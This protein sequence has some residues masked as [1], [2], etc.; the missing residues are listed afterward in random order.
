MYCVHRV[1]YSLHYADLNESYQIDHIDCNPLNNSIKNLR[2]ATGQENQ[3]NRPIQ[4]NNKVGSKGV[5]INKRNP[6]KKYRAVIYINKRQINLGCFYTEFEASEAYMLACE[7]HFGEF[8][9]L[10]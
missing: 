5:S 7:L 2:I 8:G 6:Y 9:R 10:A 3:R 4:K 1:V